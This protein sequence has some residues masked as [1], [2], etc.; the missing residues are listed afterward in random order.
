[1]SQRLQG[2]GKN[3]VLLEF[4]DKTTLNFNIF[5]KD[6]QLQTQIP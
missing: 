4:F 2:E 1:M 3:K 5:S 6:S